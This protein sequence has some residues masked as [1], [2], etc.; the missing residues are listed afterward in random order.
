MLHAGVCGGRDSNGLHMT[1]FTSQFQH[2]L[3]ATLSS[4]IATIPADG[5]IWQQFYAH[6]PG[7]K[8]HGT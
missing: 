6:V 2:F 4:L 7:T 3:V 5:T 8:L 1:H